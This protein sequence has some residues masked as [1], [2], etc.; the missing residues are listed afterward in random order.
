VGV[1]PSIVAVATFELFAVKQITT[2]STAAPA[3]RVMVR[4]A[5]DPDPPPPV[6]APTYVIATTAA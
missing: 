3:G 1:A 5:T 2:S 4:V 6:H